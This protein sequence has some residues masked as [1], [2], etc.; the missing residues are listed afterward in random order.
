MWIYACLWMAQGIPSFDA[1]V[2]DRLE[3]GRVI[4][5]AHSGKGLFVLDQD[6]MIHEVT[7]DG[8][9]K[10]HFAGAGEGPGELQAPL[11]GLVLWADQVVAVD[12]GGLGVSRFDPTGHFVAR[13]RHD[14]Q[15][16]MAWGDMT[17]R[18]DMREFRVYAPSDLVIEG[19]GQMNRLNLYGNDEPRRAMPHTCST[20]VLNGHVLVGTTTGI[21]R[22]VDLA[23]ANL[24]DGTFVRKSSLNLRDPRTGGMAE[25]ELQADPDGIP[26]ATLPIVDGWTASPEL[27]GWVMTENTLPDGFRMLQIVRRDPTLDEALRVNMPE[28]ESSWMHF[29]HLTA[30]RWCASDG[31]ELLIFEL[32]KKGG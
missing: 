22:R 12:R 14:D 4:S 6:S 17:L 10:Q 28:G 19:N 18:L 29:Q 2:V 1:V 20:V 3:C 7:L 13:Q 25:A 32:K 15:I 24:D 27:D 30:N 9:I 21:R 23:I 5:M 26:N 11:V 8:K 16:L 31:G